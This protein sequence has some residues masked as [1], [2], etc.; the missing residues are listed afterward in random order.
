MSQLGLEAG[1]AVHRTNMRSCGG[2][3]SL[4]KTMYHAGLTS[5]TL[6]VLRQIR[7][8]YGG[9]VFLAGYSLGGNVALKLA[10]ELGRAAKICSLGYVR[11]QLRSIWAHA[12]GK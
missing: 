5:D 2:T 8:A 12:S 10:G 11:C 7:A 6:T 4:C 1:Y 9:P 3:E